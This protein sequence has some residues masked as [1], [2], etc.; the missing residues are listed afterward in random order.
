MDPGRIIM[1]KRTASEVGK[2]NVATSKSHERRVASLLS[3]WSGETF[4]RRR[5]E[6]RD[7]ATVMLDMTGDVVCVTKQQRFNI[8]AKKGVGF[9]LNAMVSSVPTSLFSKWWHQSCYDATLMSK[10][11]GK[12]MLPMLFFKPQPAFDWIAI[13][14]SAFEFLKPKSPTDRKIWFPHL[15]FDEYGHCG[16]I[17][18]NVSHTKNRKNFKPVTLELE[19]CV[20]CAWNVFKDHV[21]P[22]SF[23]Y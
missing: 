22:Q 15:L 8:E 18:H 13:A 19:P 12:S 23:F 10:A 21:E 1:A 6:G 3:E 2:S 9:S 7:D 4:R 17:T 5:I 20:I 16:G 14:V 11:F